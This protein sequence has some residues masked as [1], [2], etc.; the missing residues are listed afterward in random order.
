MAD[1]QAG[2]NFQFTTSAETG[3][4]ELESPALVTPT[5]GE[6]FKAHHSPVGA[7]P[8]R[9]PMARTA[10]RGSNEWLSAAFARFEAL[11]GRVQAARLTREDEALAVR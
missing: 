6:D 10:P 8:I 9:S 3:L 7:M 4:A 1:F 2:S 11:K 5:A